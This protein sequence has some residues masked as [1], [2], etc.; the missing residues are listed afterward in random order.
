MALDPKIASLKAAG[1]YRFEFD[2]SQV[3]SIPANQTRLVVGFSKTGPFNTPVFI[4]DTAFFKQVYGDIDRNLE[5]K[6]SFF[7][8]SCLAALERGPILALNLLNLDKNDKV[9][10][11]RFATAATP[12]TQANAGVDYEYQKFYNRDKFWFPSTDD[13]LT[14][15]GADQD[16]LSSTTVNDL[17][18]VTNLGQNPIS[19]I[20]KK[21]APTNVLQ[22]AV[23]VEEWY[24]AAN[25]PGY[26]DKDSLIS[27]FFVDVFVLEGNFGGDFS[28]VT[29]YER[30]A[31]D[32][33]FQQYFDSTQGLK[34]KVFSS[35]N[36][37]TKLQEFFNET[38][39]NLRAT[40][41]ACLLPDFVDLLGNNLF[42][43]KLVNADTASTGLFVTVN[44][45]LFD[46]DTLIDG[47]PGGIDMVGHNLE[48]ATAF[49]S[50]DDVNFLSYSGSIVSDLSFPRTFEAG[51]VV[52]NSTST[53][54][55]EVPTS[56]NDIQIQISNTNAVKDAI[57]TAFSTM[58]AN[59]A[60][61][62]GSFLL[63]PVTGE[64]VPVISV[65]VIGNTVTILLSDAGLTVLGDWP[66]GAA[67]S[68][69]YI[70]EA[71]FNFVSDEFSLAT[72]TSGII[73]SYGSSVQTQFASGVLTDGDEAVYRINGQDYTSYLVMNAINYG[74][75]HTGGPTTTVN[76]I[77]ISDPDYF[78]PAVRITPYTED[79]YA[80]I[81][82]HSQFT[83][84]GTGFFVKSDGTTL[85][86]AA[87]LGVQTLK[88]ALNLGIDIIGDSLNEPTLLP[89]QI[90]INADIAV[91]PEDKT[92]F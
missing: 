71:D 15:V 64:Y 77:A 50:Q 42:V 68:Y 81:T 13:F 58:T 22:Y 63:N 27:D 70:N 38:E 88:G 14:N 19:V 52:I 67:A 84:D 78:M 34:R 21:S 37:D 24:G 26:L 91:T 10:A 44:E 90:L 7:H 8:R 18:D 82:P 48:A 76:T 40:Y 30:F 36:T 16:T 72:P 9:N 2:K 65:Q 49:G 54:T 43:E 25:V 69:T 51:T 60:T 3:V 12:E 75:I 80:N 6:D 23:T 45:N 83:L 86:P 87:D 62:V 57:W 5:R 47:V 39:V 4:P 61:V 1:T 33:T 53:I 56:G 35:D 31:A 85:L 29:P 55:T 89:N 66:T 73:G 92:L 41:T 17:L 28:S 79:S 46:G 11:V 59:T 32:P 20:V 74:F